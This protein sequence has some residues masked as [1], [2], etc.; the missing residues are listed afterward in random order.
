MRNVATI[1]ACLAIIFLF[2][3]CDT[4]YDIFYDVSNQTGD[5]VRV[6]LSHDDFCK[7][8]QNRKDGIFTI[9]PGRTER[10]D[11]EGG[12]NLPN[13]VPEDIYGWDSTMML[14]SCS[15]LKIYVGE[16]LLPDSLYYRKNWDYSAQKLIG[17]Y[18][19][20]ITDK[21]LTIRHK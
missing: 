8:K 21:Q 17:I 1:V 11:R 5:T 10:I 15:T 19:L 14:P 6:E 18:T 7:N 12:L 16:T 4:R 3:T 9:L 20:R 13:Y 2:A